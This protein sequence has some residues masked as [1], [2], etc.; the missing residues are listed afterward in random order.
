MPSKPSLY[1]RRLRS[2]AELGGEKLIR[3]PLRAISISRR[4]RRSCSCSFSRIAWGPFFA[5]KGTL[6]IRR[7]T[8]FPRDWTFETGPRHPCAL[9]A[10]T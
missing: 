4:R 6:A 1:L 2:Q 5:L 7:G 8:L 9:A 10:V 3:I